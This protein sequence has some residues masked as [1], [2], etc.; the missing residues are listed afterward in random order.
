ML[1]KTLNPNIL[2]KTIN[3]FVVKYECQLCS[4]RTF[5]KPSPHKCSG[6]YRKRKLIWH[7]YYVPENVVLFEKTTN[8]NVYKNIMKNILHI[9]SKSSKLLER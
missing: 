5:D 6:G 8:K 9:Y 4:R 2:Q 3:P 1:E 7:K